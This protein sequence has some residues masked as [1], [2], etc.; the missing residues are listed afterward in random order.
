MCLYNSNMEVSP[1]LLTGG[2]ILVVS[3]MSIIT[4]HREMRTE[5]IKEYSQEEKAFFLHDRKCCQT[6]APGSMWVVRADD[7]TK[8]LY[9][10]CIFSEFFC[11]CFIFVGAMCLK[12]FFSLFHTWHRRPLCLKN[13]TIEQFIIAG[14]DRL[15]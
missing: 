1:H 7:T 6:H 8:R 10:H 2:T 5:V 4:V 14:F 3:K 9:I 13:E 11:L 12:T 15:C